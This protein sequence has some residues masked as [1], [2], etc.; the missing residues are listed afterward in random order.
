MAIEDM[1]CAVWEKGY[2]CVKDVAQR[3]KLRSKITR[4]SFG[5]L[6][7]VCFPLSGVFLIRTPASSFFHPY[8]L[9]HLSMGELRG[10]GGIG[11]H[12]LGEVKN[13]ICRGSEVL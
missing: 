3:L 5:L 1:K 10:I 7:K 6:F 11:E 9:Q 13:S 8:I 2:L 4:C 12:L